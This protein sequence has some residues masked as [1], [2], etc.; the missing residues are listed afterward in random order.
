M[1]N[2]KQTNK[3]GKNSRQFTKQVIIESEKITKT[4][5]GEDIILPTPFIKFFFNKISC[6]IIRYNIQQDIDKYVH[7]LKYY[8]YINCSISD[9]YHDNYMHN[10]IYDG[11]CMND[12]SFTL[13]FSPF[14]YNKA[15]ITF[16]YNLGFINKI[17][18]V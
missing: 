3:R 6:C 13:N 14:P 16:K 1:N 2:R 15:F 7:K 4:I 12:T 17:H 9:G 18:N 11:Y 5:D 10:T 8:G